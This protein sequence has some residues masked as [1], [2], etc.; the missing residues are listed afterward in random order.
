MVDEGPSNTTSPNSQGA[1]SGSKNGAPE[2]AQ[3]RYDVGPGFEIAIRANTDRPVEVTVTG[4]GARPPRKNADGDHQHDAVEK[5][6][7]A[8]ERSILL[9]ADHMKK[10]DDRLS[11]ASPRARLTEKQ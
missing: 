11:G 4:D 2:A 5:R 3:A 7:D 10:I 8:I 1:S 9:L 6:L